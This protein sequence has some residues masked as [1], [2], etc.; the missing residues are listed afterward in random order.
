[1]AI[2]GLIIAFGFFLIAHL[3]LQPSGIELTGFWSTDSK[4]LAEQQEAQLFTSQFW[5]SDHS[6]LLFSF[7]V[8]SVYEIWI[9]EHP[10]HPE[11]FR[12]LPKMTFFGAQQ[13]FAFFP[14]DHLQ[15]ENILQ[16]RILSSIEHPNFAAPLF[17]LTRDQSI[18]FDC[19]YHYL[20]VYYRFV[21]FGATI[22]M[23]LSLIAL[24]WTMPGNKKKGY[25]LMGFG[26]LVAFLS[27]LPMTQD[28]LIHAMQGVD[29]INPY[30]LFA[31]FFGTFLGNVMFLKSIGLLFFTPPRFTQKALWAI[32]AVSLI[33][34]MEPLFSLSDRVLFGNLFNTLLLAVLAVAYIRL[35]SRMTF[36]VFFL[37]GCLSSSLVMLPFFPTLTSI[38]PFL[39]NHGLFTLI[40]FQGILLVK[41]YRSLMEEKSHLLEKSTKDAL[42]GIYNPTVFQEILSTQIRKSQ[43][44]GTPSTLI[45]LDID[46]FKTVNDDYGHLAGDHVLK[47]LVCMMKEMIRESDPIGRLG[48]DEFGILLTKTDADRAFAIAEKIRKQVARSPFAYRNE[49]FSITISLGLAVFHP[50]YSS[51]RDWIHDADEAMYVAK[52]SGKNQII[53]GSKDSQ[54]EQEA[55]PDPQLL[56]EQEE[57]L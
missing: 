45:I 53:K 13:G 40:L 19:T 20:N 31:Q 43:L 26:V 55:L 14:Q 3:T 18:H 56:E 44:N 4:G 27:I 30:P 39:R 46:D 41:E 21:T 50:N 15:E 32:P 38:I 2:S 16:I 34:I 7:P 9:N 28:Y 23:G 57:S 11:R 37:L 42:T 5:G 35:K 52:K 49:T 54:A 47:E 29:Q 22:L 36:V 33:I 8:G 48:G 25:L 1:L 12:F 6:S 51:A 10:V 17:L 24:S